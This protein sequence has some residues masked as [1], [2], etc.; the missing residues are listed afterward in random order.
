M[1]TK[2]DSDCRENLIKKIDV[3]EISQQNYIP[4][5]FVWKFASVMIVL[6]SLLFAG[7]SD[8]VSERKADIKALQIIVNTMALSNAT[9]SADMAHFNKLQIE[10]R[11]I[12][13]EIQA[14]L[15]ILALQMNKDPD[16]QPH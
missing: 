9:M 14:E 5:S 3:V 6:F 16:Y 12:L 1:D 11:Q 8:G 7:Y 15:K 2:C 13:V 4:K 10:V